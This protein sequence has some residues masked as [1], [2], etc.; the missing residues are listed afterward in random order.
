MPVSGAALER[1]SSGQE[2]TSHGCRL[3]ACWVSV[4]TLGGDF[5]LTGKLLKT[6]LTDSKGFL[7]RMD[8]TR[9]GV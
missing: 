8:Y 6:Y 4:I 1:G 9:R 7:F 5:W 3:R 2:A